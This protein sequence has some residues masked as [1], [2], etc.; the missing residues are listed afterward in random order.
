MPLITVNLQKGTTPDQRR[1]ISDGIHAAMIDVL[2]VP[3]DDQFHVFNELDGTTMIYQPTA[4]GRPRSERM[5]FIQLYFNERSDD[6]KAQLFA[7]IVSNLAERAGLSEDD[8]ALMVV[9]TGRANW[10]ASGRVVDPA[11]GYDERMT[12]V[13]A[14][15]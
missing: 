3:A 11:T 4:F 2:K 9:E 10:W 7:A 5:M 13:P 12:D 1:A 8:V 6:V 14:A 15:G